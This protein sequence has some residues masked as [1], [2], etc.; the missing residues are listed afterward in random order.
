MRHLTNDLYAAL[1]LLLTL[2]LIGLGAF[3]TGWVLTLGLAALWP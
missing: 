1:T 3:L 2:A